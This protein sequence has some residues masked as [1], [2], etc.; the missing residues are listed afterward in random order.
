MKADVVVN[1]AYPSLRGLEAYPGPKVVLSRGLD[2]VALRGL[3]V[4]VIGVDARVVRWLPELAR[5]AATLRLFQHT[6]HWVL[7]AAAGAPGSHAAPSGW[8]GLRTRLAQWRARRHLHRQVPEPWLRRQ[9]LP[10]Y[11]LGADRGVSFSNDFYPALLQRHCELVTWPIDRLCE[12]GIRTCDG[13]VHE[14]DCVILA[15]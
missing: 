12:D 9:L 13:L 7:P 14:V 15:G 8:G 6:P 10:Q 4:A 11:R 2:G 5:Q 1:A 3:R